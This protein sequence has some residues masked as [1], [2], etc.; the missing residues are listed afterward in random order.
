MIPSNIARRYA[1][2]FFDVA[3][4]ENRLEDCHL[5]LGVFATVL[6]ENRNLKELLLNP[7]FEKADK[8]SIV[9][10]VLEKL[11]ISLTTANFLRLLVE[12]GR[13]GSMAEIEKNYRRLM[14]NALGIARVQVKT[15]FPLTTELS[16]SLKQCL[17]S[18][19]GNKVEM[20]IDDDP[21]LIG[22]IVV[23]IGDK[24]YDGS[25]RMQLNNM[26]KL[27]GEET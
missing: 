15:A 1:R 17:E 6:T 5:E 26:M 9:N 7:V 27:L 3:G 8:K 16:T 4:Q 13:I 25:I 22:G 14:D 21:S 24:L 12:K 23:R 10:K 19:T 2:A 11:N 20:Q 18:L